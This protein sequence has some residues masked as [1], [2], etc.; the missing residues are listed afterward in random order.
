[1]PAMQVGTQLVGGIQDHHV[2]V[3]AGV[4]HPAICPKRGERMLLPGLAIKIYGDGITMTD[5]VHSQKTSTRT[6]NGVKGHPTGVSRPGTMPPS[7]LYTER[8]SVWE[9]YDNEGEGDGWQLRQTDGYVGTRDELKY[10]R[11]IDL[12]GKHFFTGPGD[13]LSFSGADLNDEDSGLRGII[14]AW[15]ERQQMSA[16]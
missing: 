2:L 13:Y 5:G 15:L 14:E 10:F 11:M 3:F 8:I 4:G 1:M 6:G 9:H 7:D 16:S 12:N